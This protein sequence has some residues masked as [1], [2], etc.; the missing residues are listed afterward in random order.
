MASQ[1]KAQWPGYMNEVYRILKKDGWIQ[2]VEFEPFY[3]CDDGTVPEGAALW[4]VNLSTGFTDCS[5]KNT[6]KI[7]LKIKRVFFCMA[8]TWKKI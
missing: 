3:K 2:C 8:N 6:Q 7:Y 1:T 4:K 5:F